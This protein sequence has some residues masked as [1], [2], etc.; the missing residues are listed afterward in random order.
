MNV[1]G[2]GVRLYGA[3]VAV[4]MT[5]GFVATQTATGQDASVSMSSAERLKFGEALTVR[6]QVSGARAGEPVRLEYAPQGQDFRT[7]KSGETRADGRYV[8]RHRPRRSGN[9][10]VRTGGATASRVR[11]VTVGARIATSERKHVKHG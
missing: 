11:T 10:R 8:L 1:R 4:L 2:H 7:V 6:G 9:V 5:I 3:A